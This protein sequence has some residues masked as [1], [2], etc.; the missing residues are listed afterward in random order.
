MKTF[1]YLRFYLTQEER[2]ALQRLAERECR[3]IKQQ[4]RLA[5][6]QMLITQG[7]LPSDGTTPTPANEAE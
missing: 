5:I 7:E 1:T 2:D 4:A 3:D 6:V